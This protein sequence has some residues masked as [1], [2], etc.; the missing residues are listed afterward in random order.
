MITPKHPPK[1][2]PKGGEGRSRNETNCAEGG[3]TEKHRRGERT[4][5]VAR[6]MQN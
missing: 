2:F 3:Q 5:S 4:N 6:D 1:T